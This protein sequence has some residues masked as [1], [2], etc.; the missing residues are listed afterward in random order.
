MFTP[1]PLRFRSVN[2]DP[3]WWRSWRFGVPD[4]RVP[5][6]SP[7]LAWI[8]YGSVSCCSEPMELRKYQGRIREWKKKDVPVPVQKDCGQL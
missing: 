2:G 6:F 7:S 8:I 5:Q 3:F 4:S 1:I